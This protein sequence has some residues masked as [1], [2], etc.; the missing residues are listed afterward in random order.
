MYR[1]TAIPALIGMI[2]YSDFCSGF[3]RAFGLVGGHLARTDDL[4][5]QAAHGPVLSLAV[6]GDG[7]I[8]ILTQGGEIR[9]LQPAG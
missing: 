9:R 6:D 2:V 8:L 3:V 7:E 5:E 4:L 1:G